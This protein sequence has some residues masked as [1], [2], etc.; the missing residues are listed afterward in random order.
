MTTPEK[1]VQWLDRIREERGVESD[2]KLAQLLGV[3]KVAISQ[4][5]SGKNE[6]SVRAAVRAAE[7][8]NLPA[9][10]VIASV[11]YHGDRESNREFWLMQWKA[12][13]EARRRN[14]QPPHGHPSPPSAREPLAPDTAA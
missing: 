3:S 7:L 5:R 11:M 4:Q 9:L 2:Y 12:Q 14:A 10:L 1:S 13:T 8:L 6:M